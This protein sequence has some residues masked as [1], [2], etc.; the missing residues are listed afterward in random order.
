MAEEPRGEG[1]AGRS[2]AADT[3]TTPV[4]WT[5]L[6]SRYGRLVAVVLLLAVLLVAFEVSGLR[7]HFT[8]AFLR[9]V[10]LQH[11]L[12]GLALFVALFALGNFVQV[13]GWIFLAAAVL[14]LG[15]FWGG[16]VTYVAAVI[17]CIVTFVAIRALGGHAL[18]ELDSRLARRILSGLDARPIAS[19]ALAR[20]VF[21][22][23]PALN[24]A[25]GLSGIRFNAYVT[26]TL[27]GLPL[28]IAAYCIF[29]DLL[30]TRLH[31][32]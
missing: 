24:W 31:L 11:Q 30:A 2:G 4:R 26:G 14:T 23:L 5:R 13:P 32:T 10:I 6:A 29:F 25:L 9:G 28:P 21:Q 1:S 20:M 17:S 27:L 8:L 12:G 22:T 16:V 7:E 15:R 19:V 3:A 18:R